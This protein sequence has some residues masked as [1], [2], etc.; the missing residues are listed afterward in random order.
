M[1]CRFLEIGQPQNVS[2]PSEKFHRKLSQL[3]LFG[4]LTHCEKKNVSSPAIPK[5]LL[6]INI[7]NFSNSNRKITKIQR[8]DFL[9]MTHTV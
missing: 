2:H 9:S 8:R 5:I 4:E 3:K 6:S 7:F 1:N